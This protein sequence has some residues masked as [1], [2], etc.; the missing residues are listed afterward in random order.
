MERDAQAKADHARER[1]S[2]VALPAKP[3]DA[4]QAL[5]LSAGVSYLLFLLM[6]C[7]CSAMLLDFFVPKPAFCFCFFGRAGDEV[8]LLP[9]LSP[10]PFQS[11]GTG[12]QPAWAMVAVKANMPAQAA[13]I[14]IRIFMVLAPSNRFHSLSASGCVASIHHLS[15]VTLKRFNG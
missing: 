3:I 14:A 7:T 11:P 10:S 9:A 6:P 2:A 5:N 15:A 4:T 8:V 12:S 13:M 1:G